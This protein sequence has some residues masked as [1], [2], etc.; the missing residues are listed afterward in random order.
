MQSLKI[1]NIRIGKMSTSQ[2]TASAT[3]FAARLKR[4]KHLVIT[5]WRKPVA[6]A[7]W[8]GESE[9]EKVTLAMM[10]IKRK[11]VQGRTRRSHNND[12]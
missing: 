9:R 12:S 6:V 3:K 8:L 10:Q 4:E 2:M 11:Q 7:T 5:Y 1:G